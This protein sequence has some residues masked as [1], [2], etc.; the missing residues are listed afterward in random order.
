MR[1]MRS[2]SSDG[3]YTLPLVSLNRLVVQSGTSWGTGGFP[4]IFIGVSAVMGGAVFILTRNFP[5]A[6]VIGL[7]GGGGLLCFLLVYLRG[8]RRS[9]L[10]AQLPDAIDTLVRSLKAGHPVSAAVRLVARELPDPIGTEFRILADELTYGLDLETAMNNMGARVGQEDLYLVVIATGIQ[11]STGGNLGEI[12]SSLSKVVRER[13]KMRLKVKAMSA[14]GRFSAVILSILP[15]G[16]FSVL[17]VIAPGFYGEIWDMPVVKPILLG[18]AVW[19]M[20]GNLV[21]Y[22]L[23]RFEI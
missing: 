20:I 19:L 3:E 8:K 21:M 5:A 17:W 4:A 13:L 15:L 23:V 7:A 14:E 22:R 18:A 9:R 6:L 16:L 2:L 12:L 1:K 11:A 10:E